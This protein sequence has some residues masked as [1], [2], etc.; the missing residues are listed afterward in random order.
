MKGQRVNIEKLEAE[1]AELKRNSEPRKSSRT[2]KFYQIGFYVLLVSLL[3]LSV[4]TV[5]LQKTGLD[6]L[7]KITAEKEKATAENEQLI[8]TVDARNNLI[9][10][11]GTELADLKKGYWQL[12]NDANTKPTSTSQAQP[13]YTAP[14]QLQPLP[15]PSPIPSTTCSSTYNPFGGWTTTCR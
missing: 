6:Q 10:K 13:S 8:K 1:V 2:T 11:Y 4:Y 12:L 5:R 14:L 3:G 9:A 15:S 7:S